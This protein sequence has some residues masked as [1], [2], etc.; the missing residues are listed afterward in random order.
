MADAP[1]IDLRARLLPLIDIHF[2]RP[3]DPDIPV[4]SDPQW[5]VECLSCWGDNGDQPQYLGAYPT[6]KAAARQG[7]L[8]VHSGRVGTGA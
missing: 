3:S 6:R 5:V 4:G 7:S 8:H 2:G 1:T